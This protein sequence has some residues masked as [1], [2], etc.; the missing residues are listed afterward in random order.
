MDKRYVLRALIAAVM[1]AG[2][3]MPARRAEAA[4]TV[5][6]GTPG[7][8]TEAAFDTALAGGGL[9]TFSC[10]AAPFFLFLTTMKTINV[11]TTIDG[12][13]PV[14]LDGAGFIQL[15][16]VPS[17]HSL[18]IQ[19]LTLSHAKST[20][21]GGAIT[22][23]GNLTIV[24][25]TLYSNTVSALGAGG[26]A[27]LNDGTLTITNGSFI[28]NVSGS[29]GFGGA[30]ENSGSLTISGGYFSGNAAPAGFGGAIFNT[31]TV[32]ISGSYF[33]ANTAGDGGA[34]ETSTTMLTI[35]Q[36]TFYRNSATNFGGAIAGQGMTVTTSTFD[37]NFAP[38]AGA[39]SG[40]AGTSIS[41][42]TFSSNDATSGT[43]GAFDN[44]G[45]PNTVTD[46]TFYGNHA[47]T[48][49]A[50]I[51]NGG[52]LTV[53]NSTIAGSTGGDGIYN[54]ASRSVTLE[55]TIL[56]NNTT[57]NCFNAGTLISA[58]NNLDSGSSCNLTATGDLSG[59]DP[60]LGT[61]ANNGGPTQT[62]ALLP[63]SPA[64][65]QGSNVT[66]ASTDQRGV[67]RPQ[68]A[69]CDIGAYE[70]RA[71]TFRSAGPL[72]GWVLETGKGTNVGGSI[73]ST[74]K[75]LNVGDDGSNRRMRGFLSFNTALLPDGATAVM[76]K[77][78]VQQQAIFGNP[79][80]TQGVLL[81]DLARPFFGA[82]VSLASSD[83]QA[84]ATVSAAGTFDSVAAGGWYT[85]LLGASGLASINTKGKTQF[86]LRFSSDAYNR[87]PDYLA[88]FSG[89][90][91]A[92]SRPRLTVYYTP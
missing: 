80:G 64:I 68:G 88:L 76:A 50:A 43:G 91:A 21:S 19:N 73:S 81:A 40:A 69:A 26:A 82:D 10:G 14:T 3:V 86:R 74:G 17:G 84:H 47:T 28:D 79:F 62:M 4:G 52:G 51:Y 7:S 85:A 23:E 15:F 83:W 66:C 2:L 92:L 75:R 5:G 44:I 65:D 35:G 1:L 20:S 36:T 24:N 29:G 54:A 6:N 55:N 34:I 37:S 8:C 45:T 48:N 58:G 16:T 39:I 18:T 30:I 77:L 60:M 38:S 25:S 78:Q 57:V 56:A 53:N 13:S 41:Q 9:I 63:G 27:I 87:I 11:D 22:N 71:L 46:S 49:G 59:V 32:T 12:G 42:S 61:L 31:N 67:S 90:A 89:D 72:D 33:T 70:L